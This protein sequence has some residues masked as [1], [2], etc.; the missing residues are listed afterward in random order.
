MRDGGGGE[1]HQRPDNSATWTGF[2]VAAFCVLGLLGLFATYAAPLSYQLALRRE[3]V[4]DLVATAPAAARPG[5]REAL[6]DSADAVLNGS[7]TIEQRVAAERAAVRARYDHDGQATA[8]RL[9]L[10][11][12]VATAMCVLVGVVLMHFQR[13]G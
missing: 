7:G 8:A 6:G 13:R 3:A 12:A 10:L 1:L 5:M 4:L 9:R 11:I 2:L